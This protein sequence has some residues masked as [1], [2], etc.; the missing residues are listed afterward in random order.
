[1]GYQIFRNIKAG[2]IPFQIINGLI[3]ILKDHRVQILVIFTRDTGAYGLLAEELQL[4]VLFN[5]KVNA[6]SSLITLFASILNSW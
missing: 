6:T 3:I 4:C 1:M 2:I 5:G